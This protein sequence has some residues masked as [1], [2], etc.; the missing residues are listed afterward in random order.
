MR[1]SKVL[2]NATLNLAIAGISFLI[3]YLRIVPEPWDLVFIVL[4]VFA[5]PIAGLWFTVSRLR[6]DTRHGVSKWQT[7]IGVV[8]ALAM[9]GYGLLLLSHR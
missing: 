1:F 4:I 7:A 9:F 5:C 3:L 8:L 6:E 2:T